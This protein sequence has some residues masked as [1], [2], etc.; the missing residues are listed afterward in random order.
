MKQR[1]ITGIVAGSVFVTMMAIGS[2]WYMALVL[3]LALVGFDEFLR[4]IG[5]KRL[6]VR[7]TGWIALIG[8]S[9]PWDRWDIAIRWEAWIWFFMLAL[10]AITVLSKNKVTID[11]AALVFI[12][13]T[14]LGYGF[15]YMISTRWLEPNGL[16]WTLLVFFCIWATDSGAYFTGMAIGKRPLWPAISPKKTV[17]GAMGGILL[18]VVIAA[19]FS[20]Y[21]PGLLPIARAIL[22]GVTIAVVGQLGDLIQSAYKRVKGIK[23]TGTI[24]PGHGGVLDR[25]DSW[26]IVFPFLHLASMIPH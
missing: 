6:S 24:L 7:L 9:V 19:A 3:L 18:S 8:L 13:V 23:D 10:M 2:Y 4:M 12:G 15:H 5:L 20:V 11:H 1:I 25:V 26:L 22:L 16:F 21:D 14:Y 17:E